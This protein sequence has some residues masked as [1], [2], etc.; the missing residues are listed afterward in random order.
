[1]DVAS[2]VVGFS[3]AGVKWRLCGVDEL[4]RESPKTQS[5]RGSSYVDSCSSNV[6]IYF[7]LYSSETR[8]SSK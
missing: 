5:S 4:T 2:D 1:M 6:N 8:Q 3:P 7:F